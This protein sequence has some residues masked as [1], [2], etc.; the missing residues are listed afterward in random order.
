MLA[1]R[2]AKRGLLSVAAT[3]TMLETPRA[4]TSIASATDAEER[5]TARAVWSA[6]ARPDTSS[7]SVA[8]SR[9]WTSAD[10]DELSPR[11]FERGPVMSK[12]SDADA[13]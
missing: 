13:V 10:E 1:R 8:A 5:W 12:P 11:R 2:A 4:W 3:V 7:A 9:S 6:T